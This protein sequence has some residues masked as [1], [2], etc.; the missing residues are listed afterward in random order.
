MHSFKVHARSTTTDIDRLQ[1]IH[2]WIKDSLRADD[3]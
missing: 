3:N 1:D 2:N